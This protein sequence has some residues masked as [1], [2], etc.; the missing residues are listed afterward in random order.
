MT[1]LWVPKGMKRP[2]MKPLFYSC[3]IIFDAVFCIT[4][5]LKEDKRWR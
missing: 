5:E 1:A 4:P 2:G 3:K